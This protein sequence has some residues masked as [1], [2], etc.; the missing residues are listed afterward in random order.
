MILE[1]AFTP[2]DVLI[3]KQTKVWVS[4]HIDQLEPRIGRVLRLRCGINCESHT[5]EEI[6]K[7]YGVGRERIR[8]IEHRGHRTLK[9]R[10]LREYKPEQWRRES[11]ARTAEI[12]R[13]AE[14][15]QADRQRYIEEVQRREVERKQ[16]LEAELA[17]QETRRQARLDAD[18]AKIVQRENELYWEAR[19]RNGVATPEDMAK[20]DHLTRRLRERRDGERQIQQILDSKRFAVENE[21][22]ERER[23]LVAALFRTGIHTAEQYDV[24]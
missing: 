16:Q 14:A 8:Q 11:D 22:Y 7:Q 18:A 9:N 20:Y 15:V 21:V 24:R 4:E 6:A 10:M 3:A 13:Q 23:R 19:V 12:R 5:L 1:P 17:M 2:E